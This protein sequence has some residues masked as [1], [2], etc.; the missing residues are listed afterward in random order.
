MH[1][2]RQ[3]QRLA[4]IAGALAVICSA[5]GG[6][7]AR[8]GDRVPDPADST[9]ATYGSKHSTADE[10]GS[11]SVIKE[12]EMDRM[13]GGRIEQ[14][15]AGRVP[16]LEVIQ[17]PNGYTFRIRGASSFTGSDEPLVVIDGVPV[18]AGS[19]SS[20]LSM[21]VPQDIS[22]IEVLKDAGAA[23]MYGLRGANGVIVITTKKKAR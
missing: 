13:H 20:A 19:I 17:T 2:Q 21:L 23:G 22:R 1:A 10:T 6:A 9:S 11:V 3:A 14:V 18:R 16:G 4:T 8:G 15:I 12:G 7:A 5:C